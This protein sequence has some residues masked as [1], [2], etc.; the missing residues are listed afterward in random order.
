MRDR[1][2]VKYYELLCKLI[3]ESESLLT[4]DGQQRLNYEELL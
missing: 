2:L 1:D 3:E 4:A